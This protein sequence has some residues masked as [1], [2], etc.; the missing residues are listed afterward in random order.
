MFR[1]SL[2]TFVMWQTFFLILF[3]M[4]LE[5]RPAMNLQISISAKVDKSMT[6]I[7][8]SSLIDQTLANFL[9]F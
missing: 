2:N 8:E 3:V 1:R 6:K 9:L 5:Q 4:G 7:A